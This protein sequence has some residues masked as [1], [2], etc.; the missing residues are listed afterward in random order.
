MSFPKRPSLFLTILTL[1]LLLIAVPVATWAQV[2][3]QI[4]D[5]PKPQPQPKPTL[6][7]Q[8]TVQEPAPPAP[9]SDITTV[10]PGGATP[11]PTSGRDQLLT[12]S[13]TVNFVQVPVTVKDDHGQLV[14]G[15][16]PKDFEVLES[17]K[18]QK[19]VFFTSDPFPL[20]AA[21]VIDLSL[22]QS[23]FDK[24]RQTLPAL[25]G[26]FGQFD[27]VA[28]YTYGTTV[29]R[30]Q[31]FTPAQ[32]DVFVQNIRKLQKNA[33][34]RTGGPPVLGGPMA[35]GPSINGLPADRGAAQTVDQ[36]QYP[37]SN[38]YIPDA[39]VLN[40]AILAAAQDLA[41]RD[42][43]RRR[44]LFVISNGREL[45]SDASYS[46]VLKFL[47]TQLITVY[48][49]V[50]GDSAM[51]VYGT[52]QKVHLPA[53]G[54]GNIL[55][56]FAR[57]TGGQTF[58]ELSQQA[59]ET[60]YSQI[61]LQAK[62]QYTLGYL[63]AETKSNNYRD[64]EVRVFKPDVKVITRAGYYPLPPAPPDPNLLPGSVQK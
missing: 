42:R 3:D 9:P 48:G 56:K 50:V 5:A 60:A 30:M 16:L 46:E 17:G 43:T 58:T 25:V 59:I 29:S 23:V 8:S 40:D 49:V 14:A 39:H 63:A 53:Q 28:I 33:Q 27:E 62:N 36:N 4:P 11:E 20:T 45:R 10:P 22:P 35:A 31:G 47:Q 52:L 12:I 37:S 64:I 19:L 54:Y 55:P 57:A 1:A 41:T 51:P 15:L 2:S 6:P 7:P 38:I 13:K 18:P 21:V 26:A 34:G 24:I 61:T 44:V 32:N